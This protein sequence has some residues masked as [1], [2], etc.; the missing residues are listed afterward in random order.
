MSSVEYLIALRGRSADT[1]M[2][3]G[4]GA[5]RRRFDL[6]ARLAD[7]DLLRLVEHRDDADLGTLTALFASQVRST[8]LAAVHLDSIVKTLLISNTPPLV[9][10]TL[11]GQPDTHLDDPIHVL[12]LLF[13][14]ALGTV[15]RAAKKGILAEVELKTGDA[16]PDL[17]KQGIADINRCVGALGNE[18]W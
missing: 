11:K 14:N 18:F 16:G 6:L 8:L 10:E 12:H 9:R 7:I 13:A 1:R 2:Y 4:E 17:T 5:R 15:E 3:W